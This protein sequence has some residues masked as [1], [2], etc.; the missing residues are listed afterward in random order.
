MEGIKLSQNNAVLTAQSQKLK[1]HDTCKMVVFQPFLVILYLNIRHF[2]S[3]RVLV[4]CLNIYIYFFL[5]RKNLKGEK[6]KKN[7]KKT[8][9]FNFFINPLRVLIR[10]EV[11]KKV[12]L[13]FFKQRHF[14][15]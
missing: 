2:A 13:F 6:Q 10:V 8:G 12:Y 9:T 3:L 1:S 7:N 11:L 14:K 4:V 5:F 15:I